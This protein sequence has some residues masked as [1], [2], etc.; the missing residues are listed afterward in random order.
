MRA[1]AQM[2]DPK[3]LLRTLRAKW[4]I[5]LV[6]ES[7]FPSVWW[8]MG[9][10]V[11]SH[12]A[13][14]IPGRAT[15]SWPSFPSTSY[16]ARWKI[17]KRSCSVWS[18]ECTYVNLCL[19]FSN[20]AQVLIAKVP[21]GSTSCPMYWVLSTSPLCSPPLDWLR[22]STALCASCTHSI[23]PSWAAIHNTELG[24]TEDVGGNGRAVW[25]RG[26]LTR[27][28]DFHIFYFGSW[29]LPWQGFLVDIVRAVTNLISLLQDMFIG[30]EDTPFQNY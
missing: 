16:V 25:W 6:S 13:G 19:W 12:W 21:S 15:F 20:R 11:G 30:H 4:R 26:A 3:K 22:Y 5:T 28:P 9:T 24:R 1:S 8:E 10:S 29:P 14:G 2:L 7:C 27:P 18:S 23:V 17:R